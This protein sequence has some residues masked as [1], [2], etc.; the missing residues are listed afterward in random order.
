MQG[1]HEALILLETF[2]KVQKRRKGIA[3]AP[4]RKNIG[5]D[6]ILRGFVTCGD[7]HVPLRSS[8]T[9]GRSQRYPYYLCQ[10]KS[11][12]SYGKSIP[13]DKLENEVGDIV[14]T[15]QPSQTLFDLVKVMFKSAW[16]QRLAQAE[17]AVKSAKGQIRAIEKQTEALLSRIIEA[18]NPRVIQAYEGKIAD[19]ELG[20]LRLQEQ[21]ANLAQPTG[22]FEEKLEPALQFLANPWKLW[23][24]GQI[25]LQR[26][27]LKLAFK[28]RLEYHQKHGARTPKIALPF[29]ALKVESTR[30]VCFGAPERRNLEH[31]C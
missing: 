27:V 19:L 24:C 15:L 16:D 23:T 7:C 4:A 11:C 12:A 21:M 28:E 25:T 1:H 29:K 3:K 10:I 18:T 9:K 22:T 31:Q 2:D 20:R 17:E 26:A 30:E 8:W 5:N 14:K 13:R 6:F